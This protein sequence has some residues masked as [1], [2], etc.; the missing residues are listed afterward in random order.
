[1]IIIYL[2]IRLIKSDKVENV[3][4]SVDRGDYVQD[5]QYAYEN[6][7]QLIGYGSSISS[8]NAVSKKKIT[9]TYVCIRISDRLVT[10]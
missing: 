9:Y 2:G 1:M 10:I 5:I 7:F 4:K 3:M 6:D 8:P